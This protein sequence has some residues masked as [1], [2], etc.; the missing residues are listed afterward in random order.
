MSI[1]SFDCEAAQRLATLARTAVNA[2]ALAVTAP[3]N[4]RLDMEQQLHA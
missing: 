1:S 2:A 3:R 4:D